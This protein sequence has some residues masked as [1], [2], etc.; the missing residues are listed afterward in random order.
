MM[1]RPS[2][3][4]LMRGYRLEA[5][6]ADRVPRPVEVVSM[7]GF[8]DRMPAQ[9]NKFSTACGWEGNCL[10]SQAQ[11]NCQI[12]RSLTPQFVCECLRLLSRCPAIR[13]LHLILVFTLF[14]ATS[15][16]QSL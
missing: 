5:Y 12:T 9:A 10:Y 14:G 13:G 3:G 16:S 15:L 8:R 4:S 11:M 7:L 1:N 2:V 6:R